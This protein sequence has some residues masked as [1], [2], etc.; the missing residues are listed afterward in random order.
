MHGKR[1]DNSDV[2]LVVGGK[3]QDVVSLFSANHWF[4]IQQLL[5]ANVPVD[6]L[7]SSTKAS[8]ECTYILQTPANIMFLMK[9]KSPMVEKKK[10]ANQLVMKDA[11]KLS[12]YFVSIR[13]LS[14]FLNR[15]SPSA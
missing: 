9:N 5:L 2:H 3:A 15:E 13:L 7:Y 6:Q 11:F 1:S 14:L 12:V 10:Q 8:L 4:E